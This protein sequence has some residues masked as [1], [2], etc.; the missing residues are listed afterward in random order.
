VSQGASSFERAWLAA[1]DLLRRETYAGAGAVRIP[2]PS[3]RASVICT[4]LVV[5]VITVGGTLSIAMKR[6]GPE[7][8]M[9]PMPVDTSLEYGAPAPDLGM[10]SDLDDL[11]TGGKRP[12]SG[13]VL[14]N[15]LTE[16]CAVCDA[17]IP[18][19]GEL[20]HRRP[21]VG[22]LNVMTSAPERLRWEATRDWVERH[23][24]LGKVS[25]D[26]DGSWCTR[27]V[28]PEPSYPYVV[29]LDAGRVI[30]GQAGLGRDN[31]YLDLVTRWE[32]A[33]AAHAPVRSV[34]GDLDVAVDSTAPRP[35][36]ELLANGLWTVTYG[37]GANPGALQRRAHLAKCR[38]RD[39]RPLHRMDLLPSGE[40]PPTPTADLVAVVAEASGK[41]R[42]PPAAW[43]PYTEVWMY[44]EV[45]YREAEQA[46]HGD[47]AMAALAVA[48]R[49]GNTR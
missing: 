25:Y 11:V 8:Y 16:Q 20:R 44:G 41:G 34:L 22:L 40:A 4:C 26:I 46:D 30:W 31:R 49:C 48:L 23:G 37:P 36:R 42:R 13:L 28:A 5:S 27:W 47:V 39:G 32:R 9:V 1:D 43:V 14:V 24:L 35:L 45:V 21:D 15:F 33:K 10:R 7:A 3:I 19:M 17:A 18:M 6:M 12:D 2:L 29:L 38:E